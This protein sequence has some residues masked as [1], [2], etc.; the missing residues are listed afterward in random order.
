ML[1]QPGITLILPPLAPEA[2]ERMAEANGAT[3]I[4]LESGDERA[5]A[6]YASQRMTHNAIAGAVALTAFLNTSGRSLRA[7]KPLLPTFGTHTMEL[8]CAC[9]KSSLMRMLA[10]T[11]QPEP[12]KGLLFRHTNGTVRVTPSATRSS[13]KILVESFSEEAAK[14]LAMDFAV[15]T[16]NLR[17]R[18]TEKGEN[19]ADTLQIRKNMV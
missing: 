14:E 10:E 4:R 13:L 11:M 5:Q 9:E 3:V 6:L 2:Y 15:Q 18:R 17:N 7:L 12:S 16:E 19:R 8:D 1:N